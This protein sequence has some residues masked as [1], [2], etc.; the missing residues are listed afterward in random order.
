VKTVYLVSNSPGEVSTFVRP[1]VAALRRRHPDW[2]LQVCLVPCP[3]ATGAEANVVAS[4]PQAPA[5]WR[6]WQTT[7]AWLRAEGRGQSGAVVFLG[8]DPWHALLLK[9]RFQLPAVAY[10]S[11]PSGWEKT[12]WLGGFQTV[13]VG[14]E[15]A[16]S[17]VGGEPANRRVAIAD[18]RV[19]AVRGEL[20]R[21]TVENE[22]PLTLALFPGSRW[23]HLKAA[24]GPFL[25]VLDYASEQLPELRFI[26]AASPFVTPERL[27]DAGRKP[28]QLG[29]SYTTGEL[30]GNELVT[31]AGTS[32][33]VVWGDSYQVMAQCHCALSLPG[34]NTAELAIAGKPTVVPLTSRVPIGGGG[35]LGILDRLPGFTQ[36]KRRLRQRKKD[37]L[38]LIALPNQLAGRI[39]M[40]EFV[41][42]DDLQ[43]LCEFVVDLLRDSARRDAIGADAQQVMG[44]PGGADELVGLIE[45]VMGEV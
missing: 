15:R 13:A 41:I 14:Y 31:P 23:L 4:W 18:L 5:V 3:Y 38:S 24:L 26:L 2:R 34:T 17:E 37:R 29:L 30:R 6:P 43:D 19:D 12:R 1:V 20:S 36:L 28:F 39:I 11:E 7:K 25:R 8:G 10:F 32:V 42:R 22:R 9:Q 16:A 27:S 35:L 21:T 40:P 45:A 33:E 44:P